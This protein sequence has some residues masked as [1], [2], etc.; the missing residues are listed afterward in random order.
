MS[1]KKVLMVMPGMKGGGAERV[2]SLLLN[3]FYKNNIQCEFLLTSSTRD[4]II[5]PDLNK[6]IPVTVLKE[7]LSVEKNKTFSRVKQIVSTLLCKPFEILKRPVPVMFSKFS[8][9]V[10]YGEQIKALRN[11]FK[12]EPEATII[13]F[14]QPSIPM[15]MLASRG[16]PNKVIFSER[17]D[18]RRL[19]KHRYGY[20]FIKK[21]YTRADVA[22]FQTNDAKKTY[23]MEIAEK[24]IVI[25]NPIK[26]DLPDS[27]YGE[28][29]KVVTTFCR[30]SRQKNLPDLVKAF[31]LVHKDFSDYR[32]KIIGSP[33]NEDDKKVYEDLKGLIKDLD[34]T[35]F[36]D[37]MPF[38]ENVHKDVI[39]DAVYVNSSDYEGM[40]NAMLEA[41]AIGMPVV[42]TDCPIGGASTII[43]N[44]FNGILVPVNDSEKLADAIKKVIGNKVFSAELSENASAIRDE[45]SL[46]NIAHRWM[47]LL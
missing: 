16:L 13:T 26:A 14:L 25:S 27:Y 30:V 17:G 8:F 41:M 45:L 12:E 23:P 24:G 47:E 33:Q 5:S 10:Q 37:F 42:C 43:R 34:L 28:R 6:K 2:A 19:M 3:E 38:S 32:L 40:S 36:V 44:D 22:V 35:D 20:G 39:K 29:E 31:F 21:Y 11:K 7:L 46:E 18:P 15:V 1:N 9:S 4:E